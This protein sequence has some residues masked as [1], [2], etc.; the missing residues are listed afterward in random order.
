[1]VPA[2]LLWGGYSVF[3]FS[4]A[5]PIGNLTDSYQ[6][7]TLGYN[8]GPPVFSQD[9]VAPKNLGEGYRWNTRNIYYSF[10]TQFLQY[11]GTNGAAQV[12]AA[13][14]ILN[15]LSN[16]DAYT[17]GLAEWPLQSARVNQSAAQVNVIDV[18]SFVLIE[19]M[20]QLGLAEPDRYAYCLRDRIS[21]G[22]MS[23][24]RL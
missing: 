12:D 1:M 18:K 6:T 20:E 11:F 8:L 4:L 23:Q 24:F 13:F 2:L 9:I 16:V 22:S 3:G 5:G 19:M 21:T 15:S 10:D 14:A 7:A 17:P